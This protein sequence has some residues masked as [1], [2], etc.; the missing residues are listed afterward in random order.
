MQPGRSEP[1]EDVACS[2]PIGTEEGVFVHDADA[3]AGE[4]ERVLR[5]HA[6][7]L[8]GLAPEERAPRP[9]AS[10][11]DPFD[12][13]GDA[14]G[15]DTADGEVIEEEQRLGSG[16]GDVVGAHRHE[17]DPDGVQP[18]AHARDLELRPHPVRR[19]GEEPAL[20]DPIEP[21]E[22]ADLVGDLRA[23]HPGGEIGDQRHRLGRGLGVDPGVAVRAA[24]AVGSRS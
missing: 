21:G 22:P 10:F 19:G 15:F 20:V 16:T 8:G 3:E 4:V 12:D 18:A 2:D 7:V 1:D 24:H 17:V 11:R 23:P 9:A 5:H 14:R 6:G 13:R